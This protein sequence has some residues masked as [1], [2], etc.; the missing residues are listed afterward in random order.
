MCTPITTNGVFQ[1]KRYYINTGSI[2]YAIKARDALRR[3]GFKAQIERKKAGPA[4]GGCGYSVNTAGN[5]EIIKSVLE[6]ADVKYSQF[7][8]I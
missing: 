5:L 6:K 1:M 7:G 2:T 4:S 8:E 3:N